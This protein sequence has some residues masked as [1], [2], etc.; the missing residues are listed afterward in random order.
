MKNVC[1][2]VVFLL[3]SLD[4]RA[5]SFY[6]GTSDGYLKKVTLGPTGATSTNI[7]TCNSAPVFG[8]IALYKN[9]FYQANGLQ[10]LQ[11]IVTPG[12]IISCSLVSTPALQLGNALT[13]DSTGVLYMDSGYDIYKV[14]PKNPVVIHV[15][16]IPFQSGGDLIFYKKDLYLASTVGIVKIDQTNP[17]NSTLHIPIAQNIYGLVSIAYSSTRNKIYALA[18]NGN[19]TDLLELDME[20]KT[21]VGTI[22]TLPYI[23]YDAA[24]DVEDGEIPRIII[25]S[26]QQATPCPYQGKVSM[27]VACKNPLVDYQYVL[28]DTIINTT[29][30]FQVTP[31]TYDLKVKSA[32]QTKDTTIIVA[33]QGLA[34]PVTMI[35]KTDANCDQTGQVSFNVSNG[36]QYTIQDAMGVYP[37][38]HVFTGLTAGNYNFYLLNSRGCVVDTLPVTVNRIKCNIGAIA[39]S[40]TKVCNDL[41]A[42]NVQVTA[43]VHTSAT[44]TYTL[45]GITNT[46][47]TFAT[48]D[49]G[50]YPL[51]VLTSDGVSKD[52]TVTVPDFHLAR[53]VV[54]HAKTDFICEIP[55]SI[56]VSAKL[57][58]SIYN[59][60]SGSTVFPSGHTF[61]GLTAANYP[62]TVVDRR[63]CL[64]DTLSVRVNFIKCDPVTF[65]NTFTP[66]RDGTNDIFLPMQGGIAT[67]FS[68]SVYDRFGALLFTSADLHAGWDGTY[69][70]APAPLGTYYWIASYYDQNNLYRTQSGSVLLVR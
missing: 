38:N 48:L 6:V 33:A 39:I 59:I 36:N 54:I 22:A 17:A 10:V 53:P 37:A 60:R 63:G 13:V 30:S 50:S 5:Q 32:V 21:I 49:P 8:S 28:N 15:G 16:A 27:Q 61:T 18:V 14:D 19:T 2:I 31:G 23:V 56:T 41:H 45:N 65:P 43:T 58:D 68:F 9:T 40:I 42:G 52:T 34:K 11:G 51:H 29:G 3:L 7:G 24:S 69:K 57:A 1:L 62:F 35:T 70:G 67:R 26:V 46:T 20:N 55:G 25:D 64:I 66:N 12:S 4:I 47:G 44:N